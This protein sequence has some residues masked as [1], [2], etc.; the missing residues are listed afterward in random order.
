MINI[1]TVTDEGSGEKKIEKKLKRF[2]IPLR[3]VTALIIIALLV[4]GG[5]QMLA[6]PYD[7]TRNTYADFVVEEGSDLSAVASDLQ[8]QKFIRSSSDFE[9]LAKITFAKNFKPGTYYI[10]AS[11]NSLQILRTLQSGMTTSKGF[12]VPPGYTVEQ[13]ASALERDG[14]ADRNAFLE[15]AASP[16]IAQLD[17]FGENEEGHRAKE[18]KSEAEY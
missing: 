16:D 3:I 4:L 13:L 8:E 12:T 10:S 17:I 14:L 2:R 9:R 15:A 11:M 6:R 7:K 5:V 1:M 18:P